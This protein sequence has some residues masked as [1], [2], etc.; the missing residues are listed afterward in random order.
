MAVN[1]FIADG[2]ARLRVLSCDSQWFGV[3]YKEDKPEVVARIAALIEA[4]EYPATLFR[5]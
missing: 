1:H 5:G 3:T 4:G 2:S